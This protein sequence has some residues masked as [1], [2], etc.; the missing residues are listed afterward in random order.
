MKLR[1]STVKLII[2]E[3]FLC[4]LLL[5]LISYSENKGIIK[6]LVFD[7]NSCGAWSQTADD[8]NTRQAYTQWFRGFLS[9]YNYGDEKY[10]V[11]TNINAATITLFIDKYCREN[12]LLPFTSAAFPLTKELRTKK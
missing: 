11:N 10:T 3:V 4:L 12:P 9:G 7:D 5:P 1:T 6:M 8:P 2:A